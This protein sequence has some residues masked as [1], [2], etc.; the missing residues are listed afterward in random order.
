M[1]VLPNA[2]ASGYT[3][4]KASRSGG[5]NNC[6]EVAA[7]VVPHAL[8]VRDSKNPSGPAVVFG[9]TGWSAFVSALKAGDLV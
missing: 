7:G 4:T 2:A 1:T 6:L 8:P 5:N 3:W 9:R